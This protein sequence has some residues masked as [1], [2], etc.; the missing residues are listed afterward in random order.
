M[1]ITCDQRHSIGYIYLKKPNPAFPVW[2]DIGNKEI[3]KY[4]DGMKSEIQVQEAGK[5]IEER[6]MGLVISDKNYLED[7]DKKFI[8]E[9]L[10]DKDGYIVGIELDISKEELIKGVK[11]KVYKIYIVDWQQQEHILLTLAEEDRVFVRNNII[12]AAN[13]NK[14]TYYFV[15]IV[16]NIAYIKALLTS[17]LDLYQL[18]YLKEPDFILY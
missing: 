4:L 14:D 2:K 17:R 6:I 9:Y 11:E 7:L 13:G 18:D 5:E 15:S 10:N 12:Y 1:I 16:D 3:E 8:E